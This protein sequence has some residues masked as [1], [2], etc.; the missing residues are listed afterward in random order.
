MKQSIITFFISLILGNS[1]AQEVSVSEN[2]RHDLFQ[3]H[4]SVGWDLGMDYSAEPSYRI[5]FAR[6]HEQRNCVVGSVRSGLAAGLSMNPELSTTAVY[7]N[8]WL[9]IGPLNLG[10]KLSYEKDNRFQWMTL[11]PQIGLGLQRFRL[12]YGYNA[13]IFFSDRTAIPKHILGIG[14]TFNISEL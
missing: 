8:D 4:Q 11:Q 3:P 7:F 10:L 12:F 9:S 6:I 1:Y 14:Y 5:G 2:I 13:T